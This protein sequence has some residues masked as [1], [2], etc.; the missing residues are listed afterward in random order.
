MGGF[1]RVYA[2]VCIHTYTY[3][4]ILACIH[5]G[6]QLWRARLM[7]NQCMYVCMYIHTWVGLMINFYVNIILQNFVQTCC[8]S[9]ED[10]LL[11][12][13]VNHVTSHIHTC[14]H[15]YIH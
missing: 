4:C 2:R 7:E 8:M 12:E 5:V 6:H 13:K 11:K 3:V 14:M 9:Y 1:S 15:T 10:D